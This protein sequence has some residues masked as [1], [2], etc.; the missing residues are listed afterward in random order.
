MYNLQEQ[1]CDLLFGRK[2]RRR[3]SINRNF[4][5][6]YVGIEYH[7][8]LQMLAGKRERVIFAATVNKYDR[9]FKVHFYYVSS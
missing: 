1:A 5:G 2:E 9:K 3:Y 7:P 6:D 4:V 8:A